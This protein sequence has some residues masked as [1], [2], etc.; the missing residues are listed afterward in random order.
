LSP[1]LKEA[2]GGP[3][4]AN[5]QFTPDSARQALADGSADAIAWG[6]LFIA[7]PDLP[8]RLELGAPLNKPVPETFYAQGETGYTD[9]PA[10]DDAA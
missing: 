9:Y 7:N 5:E 6:K 4:I 1:R 10:L 2:F 3:L 8:R